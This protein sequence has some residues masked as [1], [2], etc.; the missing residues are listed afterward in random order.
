MTTTLEREVL[1]M[2]N[3]SQGVK[4]EG[5]EIGIRK[6]IKQGVEE[7]KFLAL[8]ELVKDGTLSVDVAAAKAKMTVDEFKKAM[9]ST[10]WL[11]QR[12][13]PADGTEMI[14]FCGIFYAFFD[15]AAK[16]WLVWFW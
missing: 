14:P 12:Q 15:F 5:I 11:Y 13:A 9:K 1:E 10:F 16:S 8:A 7:G 3:L 4:E 6:G 2:C